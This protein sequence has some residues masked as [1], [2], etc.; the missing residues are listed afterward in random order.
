MMT[1]IAEAVRA[2]AGPLNE[3]PIED[4][5]RRA[6]VER[7]VSP[8]RLEQVLELLLSDPACPVV[9][10][11]GGTPS[12]DVLPEQVAILRVDSV[13]WQIVAADGLAG[14]SSLSRRER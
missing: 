14:I 10:H 9:P 13:S 5:A 6:L 1:W 4:I 2:A 3:A 8:T 11:R 12:D 7:S